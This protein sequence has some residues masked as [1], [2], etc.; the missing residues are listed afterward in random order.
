MFRQLTIRRFAIALALAAMGAASVQAANKTPGAKFDANALARHIDQAI[1]QRLQEEGVDASTRT[2]D[3]EFL[4]RVCLDLTGKIPTA[5]KAREFLD[6][7]DPNKRAK[8]IDELLDSKDYAKRQADIWQALMLPR[9]SDNRRLQSQ[10]LVAWLDE[11][12]SKNQPW[13]KL[14]SDILTAEGPQ[15]KNGATTYWVALATA[16]KMNDSVCSLFLGVQLQCAQCHN[17][18]FTNWKQDE[19]WEMAAF[20]LKVQTTR[21]NQA[22][23]NGNSPTVTEVATVRRGRGLPVDAKILPPRFLQS[24]KPTVKNSEPLR[25]V[26]AKWVTSAEN[27]YFSKAMINRTWALL[28]G[29]GFVNPID[30]MR[31]ENP[32]TYPDLLNEMAHQFSANGFDV[33]YLY[34]AICN[35]ET[36]QRSS[37]PHGTN[38]GASPLLFSK[39]NMKV[40]TPEQLYDSFGQVLGTANAPAGGRR[41]GGAA[42]RGGNNP[43]D[44]FVAFFGIEDGSDPTE[45]QAGIPQ[46]LRMMN[47]PQFNNPARLFQ[48]LRELNEPEK[49]VEHLFLSTLS[50]R[51]TKEELDRFVAHAK[52]ASN[53]RDAGADILWVLLNCSEFAMNK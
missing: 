14:V 30:D 46:V 43:R 3:A 32:A 52:K 51:P 39:M 41:P 18:P 12:F 13:D 27:P 23:R 37:K 34:R 25:P 15:D 11:Q 29:R 20:F 10:P 35:S 26:L 9:N 45:Y 28:F 42:A 36:Y 8:L 7:T 22:A 4:R 24:E 16:D 31:E 5:E 19:Y 1:N 17:H 48:T 38:E 47:S 44:A 2:T 40:L 50:R 6:S 33:K 53:P 49:V 21:A